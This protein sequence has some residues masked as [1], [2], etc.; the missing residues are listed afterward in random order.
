MKPL[1]IFLL[2]YNEETIIKKTIE[3]YRKRFIDC[4]I[5]IFDNEST[6]NSVSIAKSLGCNAIN[7][8][9]G[10]IINDL[11]YLEIKNNC[12]KELK[13]ETWVIVADMDEWLCITK[14]DLEK[15]ELNET[16]ILRTKGYQMIGESKK[17]DLTDIDFENIN[18]GIFLPLLSKNLCFLYPKI[19]D[20][21]YSV[22]AHE[23]NPL[24]TVKFSEKF[25]KIKHMKFLGEDYIIDIYKKR[26]IRSIEMRKQRMCI[27]YSDNPI[28]VKNEYYDLLSK[29]E[30]IYL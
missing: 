19:T 18:K 12:F 26:Y 4:S 21:N 15:E 28:V 24:G 30:D 17:I 27:H 1:H 2:C 11:I 5:T 3:F 14:E 8:N 9:S 22:G 20:I 29:S 10:N 25:Y 7:Y 13:E 23:C 16:T 6:D